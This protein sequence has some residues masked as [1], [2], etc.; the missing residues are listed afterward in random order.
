MPRAAN[1][2]SLRLLAHITFHDH[3]GIDNRNATSRIGWDDGTQRLDGFFKWTNWSNLEYFAKKFSYTWSPTG[4]PATRKIR[5]TQPQRRE[6]I[7]LALLSTLTEMDNHYKMFGTIHVVVDCNADNT[8]VPRLRTFARTLRR[9]NAEVR[10]HNLT[11]S[12]FLLPWSH[13]GSMMSKLDEYDWFL[14]SEEDTFIPAEAMA[15]QLKWANAIYSQHGKLLSFVRVVNDT[16]GYLFFADLRSRTNYSELFNTNGNFFGPLS[17]TF[18]ASWAYPREIMKDFVLSPEWS[19]SGQTPSGRTLPRD[20]RASA[21]LGF[22]SPPNCS[23]SCTV[24]PYPCYSIRVFHLAQCGEWY[25]REQQT[26]LRFERGYGWACLK[27]KGNCVDKARLLDDRPDT[28]ALLNNV[29]ALTAVGRKRLHAASPI[30][31]FRYVS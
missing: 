30:G 14:Y 2:G 6:R 29:S 11:S 26:A 18:A 20:I 9:V 27:K 24:V 15:E 17:F 1:D 21:A 10:L 7:Y 13:R 25:I 31:M 4:W 23:R 28:M 12:P 19:I 3:T 8:F 5:K 22:I 16:R